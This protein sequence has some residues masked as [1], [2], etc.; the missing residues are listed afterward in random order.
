MRKSSKILLGVATLWP[1]LYLAIFLVGWV[2]MMVFVFSQIP[3]SDNKVG[4][5]AG[6]PP[7]A[8]VRGVLAFFVLHF[9]TILWMMGLL[10]IYIVNVFKNDRVTDDKKALWAVVIFLG[11]IIA[12]PIYWYLYI[13]RE[14]G[15]SL[16]TSQ[17][18]G[19]FGGG[20][21]EQ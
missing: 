15:P 17:G 11:N 1:L 8:F 19:V 13:W 2:A 14:P 4:A 12:M 10:A 20:K 6:E 3:V 7:E 5:P 18:S 16:E 9:L 21:H